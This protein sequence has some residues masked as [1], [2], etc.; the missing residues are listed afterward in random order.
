MSFLTILPIVRVTLVNL[1]GFRVTK[2][3]QFWAVCEG[4]PS[5]LA[6]KGRPTLD[7]GS[8]IP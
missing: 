2:E 8:N 6:E 3:T 4:L 7:V 1:R 5:Y